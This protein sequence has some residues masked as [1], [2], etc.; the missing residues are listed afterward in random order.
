MSSL[1]YNVFFFILGFMTT[2]PA[3]FTGHATCHP[4]RTYGWI[5]GFGRL[6]S[7]LA[8][9]TPGRSMGSVYF[10]LYLGRCVVRHYVLCLSH[11]LLFFSLLFMSLFGL[12]CILFLLFV[13]NDPKLTVGV[14]GLLSFGFYYI[15]MPSIVLF[16]AVS[17]CNYLK[18]GEAETIQQWLATP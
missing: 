9:K 6:A 16:W 11:T 2:L 7:E 4:L 10:R 17:L 3:L 13:R 15:H 18:R 8:R 5:F 14:E 12:I 1:E